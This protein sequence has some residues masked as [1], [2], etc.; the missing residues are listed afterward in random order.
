MTR[1]GTKGVARADRE[2]QLVGL[3]VAEFGARGYLRASIIDVA[4]AAGVSKPLVYS[5]FGSKEGL[6]LACVHEAGARL[7]DAVDDARQA[8]T[9]G[10]R[11]LE[12]LTA[13]F[14]VLDGCPQAWSVL[15]DP[16]LPAGPALDAARVYRSRLSRLGDLGTAAVLA[17][18]GDHDVR[19]RELFSSI[20]QYAVTAAVRWWLDHPDEPAA[21]MPA[22]CA[23][24]LAAMGLPA[25]D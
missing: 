8:T 23:R 13:I 17:A 5:Y 12:T 15:N 20:W 1:S 22:R 11:A 18:A 6:A 21:D 3:A 4:Q 7:A 16:T 24:I 25:G 2:R 9:A 19:D 10:G 14:T